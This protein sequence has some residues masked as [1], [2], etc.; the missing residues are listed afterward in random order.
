VAAAEH[1]DHPAR[2]DGLREPIGDGLDGG[3]L[4]RDGVEQLAAAGQV[5]FHRLHTAVTSKA[6]RC[7]SANR[8]APTAPAMSP[9]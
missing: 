7:S 6:E 1:V 5:L 8:A 9:S 2:E 4:P 3:V